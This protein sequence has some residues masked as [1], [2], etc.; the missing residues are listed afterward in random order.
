[1][2]LSNVPHVASS[3]LGFDLLG[4]L[5]GPDGRP[6]RRRYFL[7]AALGSAFIWA[8]AV[9]VV[10]L[11]PRVWAANYTLILP[12]SDPDG[13]VSLTEV[14]QAYATARST[15]DG[16]S[17]DPRVNYR[18][19]MMSA[20]VLN[21]AAALAKVPM[22]SFG[23]PRIKLIDQSSVIEVEVRGAS[24]QEALR[25]AQAVH[26]A[27]ATRLAALRADETFQRE[28]AIEQTI[29]NSRHRLTRAQQSL[30]K[31]KVQ[32]SIIS[33]KQLEEVALMVSELEQ[34]AVEVRQRLAG[35][36]ARLQSLASQL[37]LS[38][39]RAG[40]T[41]TLQA[42][43]VFM[44]AFRQF[45]EAQ[46]QMTEAS[47]KWG[48]GHPKVRESNGKSESASEAM[49]RRA[50][51][52]LS[53]RLGSTDLLGLAMI[54]QD[55]SRD[56]LLNDLVRVAAETAATQAELAV[57][58]GQYATARARMPVL[59]EEAT[60]LSEL[61]R[62]VS[63]TEAVFTGLAGKTDIGNTNIYSSYPLVQTLVS[64]SQPHSAQ[65]PKPA[66]VALGALGASLL[67]MVALSLAWLRAKR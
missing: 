59:A 33:G 10:V 9:A 47:H 58:E 66:F 8:V 17:L 28:Q 1:M 65:S 34:K 36:S 62:N 29:V 41:L 18:Q 13:R 50:R 32:S 35:E 48:E 4:W 45:G 5:K 6:R 22:A 31:F 39:Q 24:A 42:D 53:S 49:L 11:V 52:V 43:A 46:A 61:E 7:V 20:D 14:G 64:P 44:D 57:I 37:G 63:F 15:Y 67:L 60:Q 21:A 56:A 23:Q 40:W 19:I 2:N 38:P 55:R 25:K 30:L 51:A 16:K 26:D 54:L 12:S 3:V 27:F